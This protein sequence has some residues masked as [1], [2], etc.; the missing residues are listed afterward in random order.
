M[1][2]G[3]IHIRDPFVLLHEGTYYLYGTRGATAWGEASGFDVYVGTD[4]ENWD[5]PYVCFEND[6]SFW[7]THNYWAPEVHAYRGA[8]YLFASFKSETVHRGTQILRADLPMGPFVPYSD[9]P[10]T[11]AGW[12]CLD[13]TLYIARDGAPYIVFCHEWTQVDDGEICAMRLTDD[14]RAPAGEPFL[15]FTASSA[16]WVCGFPSPHSGS[17]AYVTDGPFLWRTQDGALFLLWA[18]QS[19]TGY[20]EGLARSDNGEIDGHFEHVRPLFVDDGG[21][22]MLFRDKNG[23][24]RMPLHRPNRH[25][26]ERPHFLRVVECD[27]GLCRAE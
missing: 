25:P 27:G 24:I 19:E 10:V 7:A 9:G 11:P 6:G 15:L 3:Q 1:Q 8:Y 26:E 22:A 23:E 21:H 13:G 20:T 5:G 16:P 17:M 14:L 12:E 18:S 2:T 4:L